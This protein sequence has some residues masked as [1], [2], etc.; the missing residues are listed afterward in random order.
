MIK[1][2]TVMT[3][4]DFFCEMLS[5]AGIEYELSTLS[6]T[7][8]HKVKVYATDRNEGPQVGYPQSFTEF[9]FDKESEQF[10]KIGVWT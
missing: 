2:A 1:E 6:A 3:P 9:L 10:Y 7:G 5:Q 8:N 4:F